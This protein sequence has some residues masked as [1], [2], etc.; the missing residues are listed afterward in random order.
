MGKKIEWTN[1]MDNYLM[2]MGVTLKH[3]SE[4]YGVSVTSVHARKNYLLGK[5]ASDDDEVAIVQDKKEIDKVEE[6]KEKE[7]QE[8]NSTLLKI[9]PSVLLDVDSLI[10]KGSKF[11]VTDVRNKISESDKA[12]EDC[13]HIL[14]SNYDSMTNED[15]LEVTNN[16]GLLRRQ[17]RV[18][19]NEHEFLENNKYDC[20][21]FIKFIKE[22]KQ[23][24][25]KVCN[26]IYRPRVLKQQL[27]TRIIV[28]DNNA[29]LKALK[30]KVSELEAKQHEVKDNN[31]LQYLI[32]LE[33]YKVKQTR[34]EKRAKGDRVPIDELV[35]GWREEFNNKLDE[36]TKKAILGDCYAI[37]R[38]DEERPMFKELEDL[39]VWNEILPHQLM[40]KE[41]FLKKDVR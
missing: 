34:A 23:Y 2:S 10:E 24:S 30:E 31:T 15:K 27:G 38:K 29:E 25:E 19:K 37:Y 39:V 16:I 22:L 17:R 3:F 1:E 36:Q 11:Y 32:K 4:M 9:I 13:I 14:E 40:V 18:Y 6:V 20:D 35:T 12:L 7:E 8:L 33:K 5:L 28:S 41:Y 26:N 21:S